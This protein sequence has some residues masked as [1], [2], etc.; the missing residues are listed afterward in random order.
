MDKIV[1]LDAGSQYTHLISNRIRRLGVYTEIHDL[2]TPLQDFWDEEVKGIV[3][4]GGPHSVYEENPPWVDAGVFE[5]EVPVLGICYGLQLMVKQLGGE[6]RPAGSAGACNREFGKAHLKVQDYGGL[7]NG[8]GEEEVVWVSHGDTATKLPEGFR[9]LGSTEDCYTAAITDG[10]KYFGL[11]F[12]PEVT[13]TEN[14]MKIIDNYLEAVGCGREW[15]S[16]RYLEEVRDEVIRGLGDNDVLAL[17]S[18]GVDSTT[19]ATMLGEI[20]RENRL[21]NK[22]YAVH[23]DNGFMRKGESELVERALKGYGIDV[24]VFD[25]SDYFFSRLEG[26]VDPEEKRRIIGDS[27]MMV[28]NEII[29]ALEKKY[30]TSINRDKLLI[31]QGTI[32]PDRI[33]SGSTEHSDKIKTHHNRSPLVVEFLEQGK[34][35]EPLQ[36]FY[37]DEVRALGRELGLPGEISERHPFPGPG[38]AIRVLNVRQEETVPPELGGRLGGVGLDGYKATVLLIRSVGVQG[39]NRSYTRVCLL[40]GEKDWE[41]LEGLSTKITNEFADINRVVYLLRPDAAEGART[42]EDSYTTRE[43]LDLWKEADQITMNHLREHD[44][45]G[46]IA[47]CPTVLIPVDFNGSGKETVVLRPVETDNFMTVSFSKIDWNIVSELAGR[48]FELP[49]VGAVLWDVTHK[50]PGTTEWE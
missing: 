35:I 17:V 24:T 50:P 46:K 11:Q 33:E 29:P 19:M 30:G 32:Y 47:Q 15:T 12:H 42:I 20:V 41:A 45:L 31:A 1:V 16:D 6:V 37:K 28:Q 44:L 14:G 13:H 39:D 25:K 10:R 7:L 21:P 36:W 43:R 22:V 23:I 34:I 8:L 40:Q 48:L 2:S 49:G 27:F 5:K 4:S 38:G 3:L 9:V 26:V 18:G